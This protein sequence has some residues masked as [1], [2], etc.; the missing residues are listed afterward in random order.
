VSAGRRAGAGRGAVEFARWWARWW[1]ETRGI[2]AGVVLPG[3]CAG[4]VWLVD[5][6]A[7]PLGL[8]I[9]LG[10]GLLWKAEKARRFVVYGVIGIA[11]LLL[12]GVI[13]V[14]PPILFTALLF[15][16]V[17]AGGA[18][19]LVWLV[20]SVLRLMHKSP[21][22]HYHAHWATEEET[23]DMVVGEDGHPTGDGILLGAHYGRLIGVRPGFEGRRE[24][25]HALVCGPSRSGKGLHLV[26]NLMLWQ[27]SAIALDIKGEL[28]RLTE[29]TRSQ[30][31]GAHTLVLD[32]SGRGN[33]YDPFKELSYSREAL[34]GAVNLVMEPEKGR[35]PIFAQRGA[36]ALYAAM[37]GARLEGAPALPYVRELTAEGPMRFVEYLSRLDDPEIRRS[38]V[39]FLG[40]RPEEMSPRDFRE[41]RF[42]SSTWGTM[43]AKLGPVTSEGILKMTGGSDFRAADLVSRPTTLY[44]MFRESELEYT[45]KAFQL[46]MLSLMSGLIRHGDLNPG[47]EGVPMLVALDEAG[48]TPIPR[49]DDLVSTIAGR[50]MSAMIYVQDLGQLVA[51]YGREKA[52]TIRG[53]C[54][55]QVYYRPTDYDTAAFVSRLSGKT[56]V[57]DVRVSSSGEHSMGVRERELVTPDEVRQIDPE[58]VFAFAG[59]KPP[60]L[61]RRLEWFELIQ[62]ASE[63]VRANP[64]PPLRE[65]PLP[66]VRLRDGYGAGATAASPKAPPRA[67]KTEDLPAGSVGRRAKGRREE[68]PRRGG[69][70]EPDV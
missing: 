24:M 5:P 6:R 60:I 57:Q 13:A 11:L 21:E 67:R 38:L 29:R 48:R 68:G 40:A 9:G 2:F 66:E 50:G 59:K 12:L 54:H 26:T 51:S 3:I 45:S 61:A 32:P 64:P 47:E 41:D 63:F 70:V 22:P 28:L 58:I 55:T 20:Y 46:V 10:A 52:Q 53:N 27:G 65:L 15:V 18:V 33:R 23:A 42:L 14:G 4:V 49:L 31:L 7:V 43:I 37:T 39:D 30:D 36:S 17:L 69:Y 44:L 62:G 25:G 35:E 16:L 1:L 56:S 34:R 19:G 8:A